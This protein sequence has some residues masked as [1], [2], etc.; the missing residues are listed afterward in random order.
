MKLH[1]G[2]IGIYSDGE[3]KGSSFIVD[4]PISRR[5]SQDNTVKEKY[6]EVKESIASVSCYLLL[7]IIILKSHSVMKYLDH[8]CRITCKTENK[9]LI[10]R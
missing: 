6:L 8:A 5:E 7:F 10:D 9:A 2:R 4:L 3:G 1:G